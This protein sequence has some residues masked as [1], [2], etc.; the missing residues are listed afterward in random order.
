MRERVE[1]SFTVSPGGG[2]RPALAAI[3]GEI[4]LGV[5]RSLQEMIVFDDLD[6]SRHRV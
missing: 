6:G 2:A 5:L 4:R 3:V 1:I